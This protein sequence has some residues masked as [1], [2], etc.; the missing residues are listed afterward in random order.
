MLALEV[1]IRQRIRWLKDHPGAGQFEP[2]LEWANAGHRR[3]IVRDF[4]II[5][6]ID[7]DTIVV[8]DIFDSRQDPRKMKG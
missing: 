3:I 2:E 4:K 7:G 6:R 8:N 5:Y 1:A